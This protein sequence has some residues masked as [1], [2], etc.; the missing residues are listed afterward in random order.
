MIQD[1]TS[2]NKDDTY[3][4]SRADTAIAELVYDKVQLVKAYNYYHGV[5]DRFQFSHLEH[6]YGIGNPTSIEFI[7]LVR[8]HV[9]ALIGEYLMNPIEPKVSCKDQATLTNIYRDKQLEIS[10]KM[11]ESLKNFLSNAIYSSIKGDG[12]NQLEDETVKRELENIKEDLDRNFL[13]NY[14]IAAQNIIYYLMQSRDVDFKNKIKVLLSDL[15]IAGETYYMVEPTSG[16]T[17]VHIKILNPLNTFVD[18][19]GK[20]TYA[21]DGYRAVVREWMTKAE[22]ITKYGDDL[23]KDDIDELDSVHPEY[24]SN[25]IM[26]INAV[27][28]RTGALM[29]DGIFAGIESTPLYNQ[30]TVGNLKLFPVYTIEWIDTEKDKNKKYIANRYSVT[31]IGSKMYILNG[32]DENAV[33]S[34]DS[35]NECNLSIN[36]I[37]YTD[38][39]G[40][41]YSLMLSTSNL[42]DKFDLLHFYRDN[43]IS[44][45]GTTGSHVDLA[46]LPEVLGDS[47]PERLTKYLAYKKQGAALFDS[48]QEG[49]P[50]NTTFAGFDDS[51]KAQTIQGIELAISRIE[52]TVSSITGVFRERLG[53]IQQRDAVKNVEASMDKSYVI[54]KQYYMVMDTLIRE[55]L[56]DSLDLAK[57]VYKKGIT[58]SFILGNKRELFTALPEHYTISDHDIHIANTAEI[59]KEQEMVTQL[60]MQ[61]SQGGQVDPEI[62]MLVATSNSLTEMKES[63]FSSMRKKKEE[64]NQ[65]KQLT[66]QLQQIQEQAKQMQS[67]LQK[68]QQQLQS[69][70]AE[71]MA[72]RKQEL[73]QEKEIEMFKQTSLNKYNEEKIEWEKKRVQ[74]EGAQLLD[75]SKVNDEIKDK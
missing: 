57:R 72:L 21:K 64:N 66:E 42:Q 20:S 75:P 11:A 4:I 12:K 27:N 67:E 70:D 71:D 3:L 65:I 33:R 7:P 2:K 31:R 62:L 47:M 22:V 50:L 45:S 63:V 49:V 74:L 24:T 44:M 39:T 59:K 5:R 68:A 55:I 28:I 32:K 40:N 19:D 35:P 14:E 1:L 30:S 37:Y 46:F 73:S 38:R 18:R 25:N 29:T 41:P 23:S 26:L 54:T 52:E 6:N 61:L 56:V 9:D 51:L 48:S 16:G 53:G 34:V 10:K 43:I 58:G 13:S 15:L 60:T 36:G 8:K 69:Y 17:N